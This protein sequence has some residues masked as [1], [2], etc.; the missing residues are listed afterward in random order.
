MSGPF[1][2]SVFEVADG[3][4]AA[5]DPLGVLGRANSAA[6]IDGPKALVFDTMLVPSLVAPFIA[7]LH[8]QGIDVVTV[9]NSHPHADHVGGNAAFRAARIVAHPA[10]TAMVAE[11]AELIDRDPGFL[12]RLFPEFA[13]ELT[14]LALVVPE[15][16][17]HGADL[18]SGVEA[19]DVAG[20]HSP[21]DLALWLPGAEV[22]LAG[23]LCSNGVCP[24]ALPGHACISSWIEALERCLALRPKV[25]IPGH[26]PPSDQGTLRNLHES[27]VSVAALG[28]EVSRGRLSTDEALLQTAATPIGVWAEPGR[29]RLLLQAAIAGAGPD[30][31]L[32]ESRPAAE[33]A[34]GRTRLA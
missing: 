10:T 30:V 15:E 19:V 16:I 2:A 24:L 8:D 12:A 13:E 22:L 18:P 14:E 28:V 29:H 25:V 34:Q 17:D 9:V 3:V 27:L 1:S 6:I 7:L 23:D 4:V 20:A 31:S 11:M 26:G 33:T 21:G 32:A 5:V